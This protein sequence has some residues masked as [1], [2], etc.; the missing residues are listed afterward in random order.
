MRLALINGTTVSRL[1]EGGQAFANLMAQQFDAVIDVTDIECGRGW[2]W[3]G[4][5]AS[6]A[7]SAPVE[8]LQAAKDRRRISVRGEALSRVQSAFPSIENYDDLKLV[9][10]ILLS[11]IPAARSFTADVQRLVDIFSAVQT[12]IT[13]IN[14]A[15][16]VAQVDAVTVNWP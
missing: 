4:S 3:N 5:V 10:E 8:T 15:T 9:R 11:V 7:F 2:T 14:N 13:S 1:A 16:T 12:A 6:P